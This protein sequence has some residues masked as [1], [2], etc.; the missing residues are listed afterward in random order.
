MLAVSNLIAI[1]RWGLFGNA[2]VI[3]KDIPAGPPL[4]LAYYMYTKC[5]SVS[6]SRGTRLY[7]MEQQTLLEMENGGRVF[8]NWRI[9]QR[10][11]I[12]AIQMGHCALTSSDSRNC[13]CRLVADEDCR[14]GDIRIMTLANR[15]YTAW[16]LALVDYGWPQAYKDKYSIRNV[17]EL[18]FLWYLA[19]NGISIQKMQAQ[20]S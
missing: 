4:T 19:W 9:Q 5:K 3:I 12:P 2:I 20:V 18:D 6:S 16:S 7:D 10:S 13:N 8:T 14:N 1:V 15:K 17:K 11:D